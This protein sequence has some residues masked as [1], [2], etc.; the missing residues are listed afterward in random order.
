VRRHG[1]QLPAHRPDI[2]IELPGIHQRLNEVWEQQHVRIQRQD[3]IAAGQPDGLVLRR[4][5]PVVVVVV[6]NLAAILELF[7]DIDRP[8]RGRVVDN[9]NFLV[10]VSLGQNGFQAPFDKPA[11]VVC[12]DCDGYDVV[13]RHEQEPENPIVYS[14]SLG[15]ETRPHTATG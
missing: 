6:I 1:Q 9:D 2:R 13:V 5:E 14:V 11:A 7:Q 10:R 4:R 3:P 15:T 12:H 8:V